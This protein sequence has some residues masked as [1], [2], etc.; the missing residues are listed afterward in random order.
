MH[1]HVMNLNAVNVFILIDKLYMACERA[2]TYIDGF[3]HMNW[4]D[5]QVCC[6]SPKT[7]IAHSQ[8]GSSD[9]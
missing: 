5:L 9:T 1:L 3:S 2:Y 4:K 7:Y 8:Q 6:L